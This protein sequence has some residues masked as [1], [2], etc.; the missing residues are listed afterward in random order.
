MTYMYSGLN[1]RGLSVSD[2]WVFSSDGLVFDILSIYLSKN[3]TLL[4][5]FKVVGSQ[6]RAGTFQ[7]SLTCYADGASA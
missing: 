7:K 5:F 3:T 2:L 6:F 1:G 4:Q